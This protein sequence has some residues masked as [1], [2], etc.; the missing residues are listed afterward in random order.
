MAVL[1]TILISMILHKDWKVTSVT[2]FFASFSGW[3][4][5]SPKKHYWISFSSP[6][7][8]PSSSIPSFPAS[9]SIQF[10]S[11][12]FKR[13][14]KKESYTQKRSL[15]ALNDVTYQN[16]RIRVFLTKKQT[17]YKFVRPG[18]KKYGLMCKFCYVMIYLVNF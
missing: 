9:L 3:L 12:Q 8:P 2:C 5:G 17:F 6:Q 15:F 13:A 16:E 18:Q 4:A 10:A 14:S 7:Q 1:K 11:D